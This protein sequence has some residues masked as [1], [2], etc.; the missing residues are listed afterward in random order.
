MY[1]RQ[2]EGTYT[3]NTKIAQKVSK[4]G[5]KSG[6]QADVTYYGEMCI[7][8]SICTGPL[9]NEYRKAV[10]HVIMKVQSGGHV[11]TLLRFR[12]SLIHI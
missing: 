11:A 6:V 4:D 2:D 9:I 7:R 5:I 10:Y 12:L 3:F 1:K 8:D